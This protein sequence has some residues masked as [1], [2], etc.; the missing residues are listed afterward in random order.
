MYTGS[1]SEAQLHSLP[2][3]NLDFNQKIKSAIKMTHDTDIP[4]IS[5]IQSSG[6]FWKPVKPKAKY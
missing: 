5:G 3:C 2:E 4:Q 6:S 1:G